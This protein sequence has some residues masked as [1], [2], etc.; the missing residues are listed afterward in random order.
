LKNKA[1]PG[2]DKGKSS[3]NTLLFTDDLV[4]IFDKEERLQRS[5]N[6]MRPPKNTI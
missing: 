5:L 4:L 3:I 6:R 1:H 2:I